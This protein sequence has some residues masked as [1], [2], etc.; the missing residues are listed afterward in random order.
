MQGEPLR[1]PVFVKV[2]TLRPGTFGHNLV[3]KVL[4]S[5]VVVNRARPDGSG[6]RIAEC[7]VADDTGTVT[8][9]ARNAQV[10]VAKVGSTI[11]VRNAKID[12]FKG[13]MRLA[14]DKWGLVEEAEP[15]TFE[16]KVDFDL[17]AVEYELV[18][19]LDDE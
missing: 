1:K 19:A 11:C 15:A 12:M 14:V 2:E 6:V 17:S 13:L 16:P 4:S 10:E 9:T 18:P 5:K 3:V 7:Q 8:L